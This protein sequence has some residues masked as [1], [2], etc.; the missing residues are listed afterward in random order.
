M[1]VIWTTLKKELISYFSSPVAYVIAVL[2][3]LYRGFE[4]QSVVK[5]VSEFQLDRPP[6]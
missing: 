5:Q 3:Y 4:V 2:F 6:C 1:K